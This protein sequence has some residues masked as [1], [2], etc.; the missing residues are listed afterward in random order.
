MPAGPLTLSESFLKHL[1]E[2]GLR[3]DRDSERV[4]VAGGSASAHP[5]ES[6]VLGN[7]RH[8]KSCSGTLA[9]RVPV[10]TPFEVGGAL[11]GVDDQQL[12]S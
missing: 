9:A 8:R 2:R 5:R 1:T 11:W 3:T 10:A 6:L 7:N 12:D 4:G